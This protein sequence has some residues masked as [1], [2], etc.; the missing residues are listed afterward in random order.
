MSSERTSYNINI[1]PGVHIKRLELLG[2]VA[3]L[4]VEGNIDIVAVYGN[5]NLQ[6]LSSL[7]KPPKRVS[8]LSLEKS[9]KLPPFHYSFVKLRG[10][11]SYDISDAII[12]D[13]ALSHFIAPKLK[14][15]AKNIKTI[16]IHATNLCTIEKYFPDTMIKLTY[17]FCTNTD[18][19]ELM[20]YIEKFVVTGNYTGTKFK[21]ELETYRNSKLLGRADDEIKTAVHHMLGIVIGRE[22]S[23]SDEYFIMHEWAENLGYDFTQDYD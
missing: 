23:Y 20:R 17:S 3:T 9:C 18:F 8:I 14:F 13:L 1:P 6:K 19:L 15:N 21:M 12:D 16:S 4:Q 7:S 10:D 11:I 5:N 22:K 2:N